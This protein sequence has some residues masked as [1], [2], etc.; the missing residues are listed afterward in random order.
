MEWRPVRGYE[1]FYEVS[2]EGAVKRVKD[3][4][5]T[6]AGRI[7][8]QSENRGY[9]RVALSMNGT[10]KR[11]GLVHQLVAEA[12]ICP[13]PTPNHTVNHINGIKSDN[14][15]CNLEWATQ[16]ENE[17]HALRIGLKPRGERLAAAK[18]TD[19][20]VRAIRLLKGLATQREIGKMFGVSKTVIGLIHRD[21]SWTHVT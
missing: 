6:R 11:T 21:Q 19:G 7:C 14:R 9:R 1:G 17:A 13:R 3:A 8:G 18:L 4:C 16:A 10:V 15:P 2:D 20:H 5:G 12:F